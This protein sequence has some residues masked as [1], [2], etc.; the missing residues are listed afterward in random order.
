MCFPDW[1]FASESTRT[2]EN[3][4]TPDGPVALCNFDWELLGGISGGVLEALAA[5][6]LFRTPR[7]Y[8]GAGDFS[9]VVPTEPRRSVTLM[10]RQGAMHVDK[11]KQI[12]CPIAPILV[13]DAC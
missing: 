2:A 12:R 5:S 4:W 3:R 11:R 6:F 10:C 7:D 8:F 13:I 9:P 1:I